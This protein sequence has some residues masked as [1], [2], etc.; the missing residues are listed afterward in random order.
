MC[1]RDRC[2]Q[3]I[4]PSIITQPA[5]QT[6]LAGSNVTFTVA[7]AGTTP[8]SYQWRWSGTNIAGATGSSLALSN[9]QPAQAGS[10]SVLVTNVAGSVIS[11]NAVLTINSP[12][13]C[14]PPPSGLVGWWAGESNALDSTGSNSGSVQGT[15]TFAPGVV[16]QAFSFNPASG[17]ILVLSLIHI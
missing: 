15:A 7:A 8:L 6:V 14:V 9:V 17:T 13:Q 12:A 2:P 16:G 3:G 10:Y 5:S 11:S 1:I 4:T